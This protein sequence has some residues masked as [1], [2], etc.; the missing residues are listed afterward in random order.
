MNLLVLSLLA[1]AGL[2]G[3]IASHKERRPLFWLGAGRVAGPLAV[4]ILLLLPSRALGAAQLSL[5]RS[6]SIV[7]EINGLEEMR[8]RGL[9]SDDEFRSGKA[10]L[11]AW[12]L[13]SEIPAAL[14]PQRIWADGRRTWASYQP[15]TRAALGDLARRYGLEL[16]WRDDV[17]FEIAATY[18]VQP[19]LSFAFSLGLEKGSIHCWGDGWD[20]G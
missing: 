9:I 10:Q 4:A 14:T 3:M 19:G 11:L 1:S 20:L 16:C 2:C 13:S 8:Q 7:E 18:P 17:P 5:P 6:R 15:A 12:P